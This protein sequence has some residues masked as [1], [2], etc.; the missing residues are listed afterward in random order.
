MGVSGVDFY[1]LYCTAYVCLYM[2]SINS[3][4]IYYVASERHDASL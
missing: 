3:N 4:V 1:S 2:C